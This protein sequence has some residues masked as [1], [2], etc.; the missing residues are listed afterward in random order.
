MS[1]Y[2]YSGKDLYRMEKNLRDRLQQNRID[3]DHTVVL[4]GSDPKNFRLE[5]AFM[6]C[7][8]FSLFDEDDKK[9]IIVK[10][11]YFLSSSSKVSRKNA[12]KKKEKTDDKKE[13]LLDLLT[14][15]LKSSHSNDLFFYCDAFDADSRRKEYKLLQKYEVKIINFVPMNEREFNSYMNDQLKKKGYHLDSEAMKVLKERVDTDTMK[16]HN[17]MDKMDLY[18]K[19]DLDEEDISHIV[20][21]NSTLNAFRLSSMFIQGNLAGAV[22]AEKEMLLFNYD[23]NAMIMMIASRLRSLYNMLHLYEQGLNENDIAVRLHANPWAVKFG[24]Q[25]CRGQRAKTLLSYLNELA[26]L[27]QGI[28]AGMV[29]PKDGFESFLLRNGRGC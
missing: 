23:Y 19:K 22:K 14:N 9:A 1:I 27:D 2:L 26:G 6:A 7:D 12:K 24:L 11:P 3:H 10:N 5:S 29:D 4:D 8:S 17:A 28:K 21:I 20:P 13:E 18:G 25:D 16:L 15:F